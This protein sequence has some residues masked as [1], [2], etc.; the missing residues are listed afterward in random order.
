M[1]NLSDKDV[2]LTGTFA[3]LLWM[4][5]FVLVVIGMLTEFRTGGLGL[6]IS[7]WGAV[8]T[9]RG[10]VCV[11][12]EQVRSREESAFQLGRDSVRSLR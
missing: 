2:S 12:V 4:L 1:F 6:L 10:F 11:G 9:I 3:S 8:L 5:G 7:G